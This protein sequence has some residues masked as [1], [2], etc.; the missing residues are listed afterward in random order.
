MTM[1]ELSFPLR[2]LRNVMAI[3]VTLPVSPMLPTSVNPLTVTTPI[4]PVN[5]SN[6]VFGVDGCMLCAAAGSRPSG[7]VFVPENGGVASDSANA[8]ASP[9]V[10]QNHRPVLGTAPHRKKTH[11]RPSGGRRK[12]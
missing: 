8:L 4:S 2:A 10:S 6:F 9:P 12:R 5:A 11:Q 3:T 7:L 1:P